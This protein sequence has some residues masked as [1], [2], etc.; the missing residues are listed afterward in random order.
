[1]DLR[2]KE[3]PFG[4]LMNLIKAYHSCHPELR[5]CQLLYIAANKAGWSNDD[6]FYCPDDKLSDGLVKMLHE[7]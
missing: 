5:L 2:E 1:M 6:L 4:K 7:L 3:A